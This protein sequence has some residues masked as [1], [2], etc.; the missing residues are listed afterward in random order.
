MIV[1]AKNRFVSTSPIT[2][3]AFM[4]VIKTFLIDGFRQ[5]YRFIISLHCS[6]HPSR[7]LYWSRSDSLCS[8][9]PLPPAPLL[10][11]PILPVENKTD[12]QVIN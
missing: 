3:P 4:I 2:H 8:L 1:C 7:F 9:P 5:I 11:S 10:R 12:S 6:P